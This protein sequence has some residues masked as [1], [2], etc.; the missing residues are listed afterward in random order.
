MN[1][2]IYCYLPFTYL[3]WLGWARAWA[4][5][6]NIICIS[7]KRSSNWTSWAITDVF[8]GLQQKDAGVRSCMWET[9]TRNSGVRR[10][11]SNYKAKHLLLHELF[12]VC[13]CWKSLKIFLSDYGSGVCLLLPV[14]FWI[15][16]YIRCMVCK[17]FFSYSLGCLSTL[18]FPFAMAEDIFSLM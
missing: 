9:G 11:C 18:D 8:Q 16:L 1:I 3:Q 7:Q 17:Y 13:S 2:A 15:W 4:R 5:A 10:E 12:E 14:Y 6:W